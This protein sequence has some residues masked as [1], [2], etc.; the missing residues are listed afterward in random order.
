MLLQTTG[1]HV[2]SGV[3]IMLAAMTTLPAAKS[4]LPHVA[5]VILGLTTLF[6]FFQSLLV[7]PVILSRLLGKRQAT[8]IPGQSTL[9]HSVSSYLDRRTGPPAHV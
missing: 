4:H 3:V 9:K 1:S 7:L 5:F 8:G 2:F 6:G